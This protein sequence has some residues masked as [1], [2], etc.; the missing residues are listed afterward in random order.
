MFSRHA[1]KAKTRSFQG[2][3]VTHNFSIFRRHAFR[4]HSN[5]RRCLPP[6][7]YL[8]APHVSG[9]QQKYILLLC[10]STARL[11]NLVFSYSPT[12]LHF[13]NPIYCNVLSSSFLP[14]FDIL[15][16]YCLTRDGGWVV[17][18]KLWARCSYSKHRVPPALRPRWFA[19]DPLQRK[20][21]PSLGL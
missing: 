9:I 21:A 13:A 17:A 7:A 10:R 4:S 16:R 3:T 19:S 2:K 20:S 6:Y 1:S 12:G 8:D 11:L 5:R 14:Y 18:G 15:C